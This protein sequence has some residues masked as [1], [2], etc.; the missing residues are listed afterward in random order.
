MGSAFVS[1]PSGGASTEIRVLTSFEIGPL[2]APLLRGST[3]RAIFAGMKR[4]PKR[5][6]DVN[7]LAHLVIGIATGQFPDPDSQPTP[8]DPRKNQAAVEL[9]RL[10]GKKGGTARANVLTPQRRSEI[11]KAA[12]RRRWDKS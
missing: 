10:G 5:P 9:G 12:A 4:T 8:I 1:T 7:Q 3:R 11:A 6:R 2:R